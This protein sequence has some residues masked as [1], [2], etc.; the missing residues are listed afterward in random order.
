VLNSI[1]FWSGN[2]PVADFGTKQVQGQDGEY[3][4]TAKADGYTISK[5]GEED[6]ALDLIYN[7]DNRSWN[8]VADG[9]TYE[10]F[11]LNE[12]GTATMKLQDGSDIVVLPNAQSVAQAC[13]AA[14]ISSV[15][16][17]Q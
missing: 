3:N 4:I 9:Q 12:D 13:A 6:K 8:A 5:V 16:T 11:T 10:L 14:G 17:A 15:Y 2:N 1:E 7:A